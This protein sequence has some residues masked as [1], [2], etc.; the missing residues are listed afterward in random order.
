MKK[1]ALE[2][3]VGAAHLCNGFRLCETSDGSEIG[4]DKLAAGV[5]GV[6][7]APRSDG[8][9]VEHSVAESHDTHTSRLQHTINLRKHSLRLL[10]VLHTAPVTQT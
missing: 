10:H 5:A 2:A 7:V 6:V 9:L 4:L 3:L 1:E 8:L